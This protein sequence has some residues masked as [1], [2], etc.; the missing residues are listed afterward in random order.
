M[1]KVLIAATAAFVGLSLVSCSSGD[2]E[3][4]S[5][6][7]KAITIQ[8]GDKYTITH[9]G[10]ASWD[11]EDEFVASVSDGVISGNH[12]GETMVYA[13][14]NGN[15]HNCNVSIKGTYNY[16]REPMCKMKMSQDDVKKYESRSLDTKRSTSTMLIYYP[17]QNEDIDVVVYTF[18]NN[19]LKNALVAMAMHGDSSKALQMMNAFMSERY[20]GVVAN[21][22]YTYINANN[23]ENA[24]KQ[25]FVTNTISGYEGI[26]AALYTPLK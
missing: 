20:V 2:D 15:K 8:K 18:E 26:T 6:S 19:E 23:L 21:Q 1:K 11:S 12:V 24:S 13:M 7:E 4:F 5:I 3:A 9:T 10:K 25:I 22:G 14:A 17:A 16:F